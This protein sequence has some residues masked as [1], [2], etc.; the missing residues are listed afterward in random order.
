MIEA[1]FGAL[2]LLVGVLTGYGLASAGEKKVPTVNLLDM[3]EGPKTTN[4]YRAEAGLRTDPPPPA[5][6]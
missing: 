5:K 4:E 2:I 3:R 6:I 1:L